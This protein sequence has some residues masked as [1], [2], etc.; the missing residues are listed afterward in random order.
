[1]RRASALAF[2]LAAIVLGTVEPASAARWSQGGRLSGPRS[3][4]L[5]RAALRGADEEAA[6]A[7]ESFG[8]R[9]GSRR[10]GR[11]RGPLRTTRLYTP[12]RPVERGSS[13]PGGAPRA[14]EARRQEEAKNL[15]LKAQREQK[16]PGRVEKKNATGIALFKKL[17]RDVRPSVTGSAIAAAE[18]T[19]IAA[20]LTVGR[21]EPAR[22]AS[23]MQMVLRG[24][25]LTAQAA[26]DP[27]PRRSLSDALKEL[28]RP[29]RTAPSSAQ[30]APTFSAIR[31]AR[32]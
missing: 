28:R 20:S 11:V 2:L 24:R 17:P 10:G 6:A 19:T 29:Q 25:A 14:E 22:G 30:P 16:R 5:R 13:A 18:R 12:P 4:R 26:A 27:G 23:A 7:T 1:M 21:S 9:G 3:Q 32:S 8:S 15:R 31:K